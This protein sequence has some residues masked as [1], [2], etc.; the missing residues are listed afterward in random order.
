MR[1]PAPF[2]RTA[3]IVLG[4][5]IS[6][7]GTSLF[8][9]PRVA[10]HPIIALNANQSGNWS[11]YNLGSEAQGGTLFYSI[12]AQWHVPTA[13]PRSRTDAEYSST[14]IG[15]GGGCID[16]NCDATDA[17]LI[18][19]GTEQDVIDGVAHYSAW[20]ETIPETSTTIS[21]FSVAPGD[22]M[23]ASIMI[24][25]N[26]SAGGSV[27]VGSSW[28]IRLL[29]LSRKETFQKTVTYTSSELTAEWITETP[30]VVNGTGTGVATLPNLSGDTFDNAFVNNHRVSFT[31]A[32]R[33]QLVNG[34][35]LA[36]PSNPDSDRD[37]YRDC[38]YTTSCSPPSS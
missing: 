33:M 16:A 36:T 23:S 4:L 29:D 2:G 11:G 7:G 22:L 34:N 32:E 38:T 35:V 13:S 30:V 8:A 15:I 31:P 3:M 12:F 25:P 27:N 14:W 20:W 1:L 6:I 21:N 10:H 24:S 9:P 26:V 19:T 5:A 28:T 17:T 18:Q 37:G